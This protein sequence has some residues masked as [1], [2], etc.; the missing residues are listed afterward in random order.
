M[1]PDLVSDLSS[2]AKVVRIY[3]RIKV[4][5]GRARTCGSRRSSY[6]QDTKF[7][8]YIRWENKKFLVNRTFGK[9]EI[10]RGFSDP[11]RIFG[12]R[13]SHDR[14]SKLPLSSN[15]SKPNQKHTL[16]VSTPKDSSLGPAEQVF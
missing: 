6:S 2:S 7:D 10:L 5:P 16:L 13:I 9:F 4:V 11:L 14:R 1:P 12:I 8:T 15:A 3:K